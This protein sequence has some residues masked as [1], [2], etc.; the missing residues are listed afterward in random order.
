MQCSIA[1]W[2]LT[3]WGCADGLLQLQAYLSLGLELVLDLGLIPL[4]WAQIELG[5]EFGPIMACS[6]PAPINSYGLNHI[7]LD[8]KMIV[9]FGCRHYDYFIEGLFW[10]YSFLFSFFLR[11]RYYFIEGL[12][13]FFSIFLFSEALI[14]F[15][16]L[17]LHIS[18]V[19]RSSFVYV[20]GTIK[21]DLYRL[22]L[23]LAD[24]IL[25]HCLNVSSG[26]WL[27]SHDHT[28]TFILYMIF[29]YISIPTK[30]LSSIRIISGKC[31]W[32][33]SRFN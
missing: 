15:N 19:K 12:V 11:G 6:R 20:Q 1:P 23:Y 16:T 28:L 8:A 29:G 10:Y 7:W 18:Q 32:N 24:E 26:S 2:P 4:F 9:D 3:N 25:V 14:I 27:L 5:W 21:F 13:I 30:F 22:C 17:F 33:W 31:C